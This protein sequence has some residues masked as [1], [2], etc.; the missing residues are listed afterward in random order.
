M[1]DY[2][3]VMGEEVI[4]ISPL[5]ITITGRRNIRITA[6]TGIYLDVWTN[7]GTPLIA[8]NREVCLPLV[9]GKDFKFMNKTY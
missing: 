4:L 2:K 3:P 5:D 8:I 9:E 7:A 1:S 6:T